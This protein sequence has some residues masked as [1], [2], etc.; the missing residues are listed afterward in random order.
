MYHQHSNKDIGQKLHEKFQSQVRKVIDDFRTSSE[1]L[2]ASKMTANWFPPIKADIFISHAHQNEEEAIQLAGWLK[3]NFNLDSFIDSCVWGCADE[4]LKLIDDEYCKNLHGNTYSY[5]KRNRSTSHVHMMLS[6]ALSMMIDKTECLFF[7]NT[8]HSITPK[9]VIGEHATYSPWIYSEI[10]MTQLIRRKE[11]SEHRECP[12]RAVESMD[13]QKA[14]LSIEYDV[15]ISHL[16]SLNLS[17]LLKWKESN[18]KDKQAL[19]WLYEL[20]KD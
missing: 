13:D 12:N 6:T 9:K 2:S 15:D 17:D 18:I 8:P 1:A 19:D 20:K 7:L 14:A 5:E 11:P 3:S 16:T 10:A 4:L